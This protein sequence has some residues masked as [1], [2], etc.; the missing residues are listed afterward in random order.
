MVQQFYR[1]TQD[2]FLDSVEA[3]NEGEEEPVEERRFHSLWAGSVLDESEQ[4]FDG[5]FEAQDNYEWVVPAVRDT[6]SEDF[7]GGEAGVVDGCFQY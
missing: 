5:S 6:L 4:N 2:R 1:T 3:S 7:V